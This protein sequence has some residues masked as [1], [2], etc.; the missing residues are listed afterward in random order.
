LGEIKRTKRKNRAEPQYA[1]DAKKMM[2]VMEKQ[3]SEGETDREETDEECVKR[4][5]EDPKSHQHPFLDEE[6][7]LYLPSMKI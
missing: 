4:G 2:I 7:E 1:E 5:K 6:Q 3:L